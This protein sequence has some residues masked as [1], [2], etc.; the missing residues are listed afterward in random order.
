MMVPIRGSHNYY[1]RAP[2]FV[3]NIRTSAKR[4][5]SGME[6]AVAVSKLETDQWEDAV[7]A[8]SLLPES[9]VI[10]NGA[11]GSRSEIEEAQ[12]LQQRHPHGRIYNLNGNVV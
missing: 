8:Q 7:R 11:I 3:V 1:H 6:G 2:I 10:V 4:A 5:V 9:P 12:Q